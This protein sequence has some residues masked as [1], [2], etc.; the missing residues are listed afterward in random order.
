MSKKKRPDVVLPYNDKHSVLYHHHQTTTSTAADN[1]ED[2]RAV[3]VNSQDIQM[4]IAS[5]SERGDQKAVE[6]IL[7][8]EERNDFGAKS[9]FEKTKSFLKIAADM[10]KHTDWEWSDSI[11]LGYYLNFRKNK[12]GI[13]YSNF[14]EQSM[15]FNDENQCFEATDGISVPIETVKV[16]KEYIT[17]T[18]Y[19]FKEYDN[20][21]SKTNFEYADVLEY[22]PKGN[23]QRSAY[24]IVR[25]MKNKKLLLL[26]EGT[27]S[28]HDLLTD[29]NADAVSFTCDAFLAEGDNLSENQFV[30]SGM[31]ERSYW[32]YYQ[33]I[34][35]IEHYLANEFKGFQFMI[36]G[37]SLGAGTGAILAL[38]LVTKMPDIQCLA[39]AC[40]K[41]F[42]AELSRSALVKR[43]ITTFINQDDFVPRFSVESFRT[44]KTTGMNN[45]KSEVMNE[46]QLGKVIQSTNQYL[47]K[48]GISNAF[49]N[50]KNSLK[51]G[52]NYLLNG[53]SSPPTKTVTKVPPP[54][55]KKL[56][57]KR[58][59]KVQD[60]R[61]EEVDDD[62]EQ[63]FMDLVQEYE[64]KLEKEKKENEQQES[65]QVSDDQQQEVNEHSETSNS[66]PELEEQGIQESIP[67]E[68]EI[69]QEE[70]PPCEPCEDSVK[71]EPQTEP[72][73]STNSSTS[74]MPSTKKD[75]PPLPKSFLTGVHL[76][77]PEIIY[78]LRNVDKK[79]YIKKCAPTEFEQ[80]DFVGSY[81]ADHFS[82]GYLEALG[83]LLN[84]ANP[85]Q[86]SNSLVATQ[87]LPEDQ[88]DTAASVDEPQVT[89][90]SLPTLP[91]KKLPP[92]PTH[93][94]RPVSE[95]LQDPPQQD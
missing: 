10:I 66:P 38:L 75:L 60:F 48:S 15:K 80:L 70:S 81:V 42:S 27:K 8:E 14:H 51:S 24:A 63:F 64:D 26:I 84:Q 7:V 39:F 5:S 23:A 53:S 35:K 21:I 1:E 86:P 25:D 20:F 93:L 68:D 78:Y 83:Q 34:P 19:L 44:F 9:Q 74:S 82:S 46:T 52:Y 36:V 77:A 61:S 37:H 55:P 92:L 71:T 17:C 58:L 43:H 47:D 22:E 54:I 72:A 85:P 56:L 3:M 90:S 13:D 91:V 28:F 87:I 29:L 33:I 12:A 45:W 18:R 94:K 40:P 11:G 88:S 73:L 4:T 79:M 32:F 49:S 2:D 69:S 67:E 76:Y 57:E 65:N 16:W 89:Q 6:T 41:I 30:H 59:I 95:N 62:D 50:M 31:L